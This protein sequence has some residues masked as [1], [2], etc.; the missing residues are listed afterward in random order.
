[1]QVTDPRE[2]TDDLL[3]TE[4]REEL[5]PDEFREAAASEAATV[6]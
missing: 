3:V 4:S 5:P 6:G 2:R 1:M